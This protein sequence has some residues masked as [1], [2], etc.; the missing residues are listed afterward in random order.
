MVIRLSIKELLAK[1]MV[2]RPMKCIVGKK[3][4]MIQ[5]NQTIELI[6]SK[7]TC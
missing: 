5:L 3:V 1:S 2:T 7:N 4:H 6:R